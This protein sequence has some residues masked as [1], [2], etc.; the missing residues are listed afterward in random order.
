MNLSVL[1]TMSLN[2]TTYNQSDPICSNLCNPW[3]KRPRPNEHGQGRRPWH[4]RYPSFRGRLLLSAPSSYESD[5]GRAMP[6]CR[7]T[8]NWVK[9]EAPTSLGHLRSRLPSLRSP[10]NT[11]KTFDESSA[12][13]FRPSEEPGRGL[14]RDDEGEKK[15]EEEEE[16]GGHWAAP[17]SR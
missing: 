15:K 1:T 4:Q 3:V 7:G 8:S 11:Q 5:T 10:T 16:G 17:T 12:W 13:N 9:V 14:R 6:G 2:L